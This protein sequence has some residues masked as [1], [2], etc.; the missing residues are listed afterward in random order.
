MLFHNDTKYYSVIS[1]SHK[2]M[3]SAIAQDFKY[4]IPDCVFVIESNH[5]YICMNNMET[6]TSTSEAE[7]GGEFLVKSR[8]IFALIAI[9]YF[10]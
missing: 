6:C 2:E 8:G 4:D 5:V 10:S 9:F 7:T 3:G 1:E